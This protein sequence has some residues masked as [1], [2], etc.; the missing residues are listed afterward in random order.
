MKSDFL[1]KYTLRFWPKF[2]I[3][4][5]DLNALICIKKN[6]GLLKKTL[7]KEIAFLM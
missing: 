3:F 6:D 2:F 7:E 5:F 1:L 4:K